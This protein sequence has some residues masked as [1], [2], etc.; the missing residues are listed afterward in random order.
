MAAPLIR[1]AI[2]C[3]RTIRCG[4][5]SIPA[6]PMYWNGHREDE[7]VRG[8]HRLEDDRGDAE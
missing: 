4:S 2:R 5:E 7:H 3:S 6:G 1:T 8:T